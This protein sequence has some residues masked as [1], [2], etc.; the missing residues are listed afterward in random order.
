MICT[1]HNTV[2]T[3]QL[4]RRDLN[5]LARSTKLKRNCD[6]EAMAGSSKRW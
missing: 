4:D 5:Y 6:H 2:T 1:E 3:V